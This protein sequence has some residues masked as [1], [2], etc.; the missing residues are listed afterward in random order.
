MGRATYEDYLWTERSG[1]FQSFG[2]ALVQDSNVD[3]I[4]AQLPVIEDSGTLSFPDLHEHSYRDWDP[5]KLLVGLLQIDSWT[6]MYE[7]NGFVGITPQI[8]MPM[9]KGRRIVSHHYSDGNL[10]H[11]FNLYENGRFTARV[12]PGIGIADLWAANPDMLSTLTSLMQEIGFDQAPHDDPVD[13]HLHDRAAAFALTD[14]LAGVQLEPRT[15]AGATFSV[16][17]VQVP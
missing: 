15:I 10:S 6:A 7:V 13:G 14:R 1:A 5:D 3:D 11:S 4:R 9:S 16:V 17:R 2:L 8:V 12:D